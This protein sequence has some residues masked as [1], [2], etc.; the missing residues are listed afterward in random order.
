MCDVVLDYVDKL[1]VPEEDASATFANH[2]RYIT[3]LQIALDYLFGQ[4]QKLEQCLP[5]QREGTIT[6]KLGAIGLSRPEMDM[7]AAAYR[8]Y[9]VDL[10]SLATTV[11]WLT[12]GQQEH[13][14]REY[15][16]RVLGPVIVFRD[17]VGAHPQLV[18][19][20]RHT[21]TAADKDASTMF[22]VEAFDDR[23]VVGSATYG[24]TQK[25]STSVSSLQRWSLT[26]RHPEMQKRYWPPSPIVSTADS[27]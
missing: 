3:A 7:A 24:K 8:W 18:A 23:L 4:M 5:K 12:L 26:E 1:T 22:R 14:A 21:G 15:A 13:K 6:W 19:P 9:S 17:K 20:K 25:G 10:Y 27:V 11:G 2:I 16:K